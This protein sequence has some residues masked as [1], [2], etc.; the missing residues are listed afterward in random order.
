[1]IYELVSWIRDITPPIEPPA[2][3]ERERE[4]RGWG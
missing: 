1:M 4:R 2:D 3:R